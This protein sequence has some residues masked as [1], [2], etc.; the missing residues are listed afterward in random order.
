M[1]WKLWGRFRMYWKNKRDRMPILKRFFGSFFFPLVSWR[2]Y[3]DWDTTDP[4][5]GGTEFLF[6]TISAFVVG[7]LIFAFA[8]LIAEMEIRSKIGFSFVC[9]WVACLGIGVSQS[10]HDIDSW[11]WS[12]TFFTVCSPVIYMM[13]KQWKYPEYGRGRRKLV[14]TDQ[15]GETRSVTF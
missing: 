2:M 10:V 3:W 1:Y 4:N 5:Y 6:V 11:G 12:L 14:Y 7:C 13:C 15:E 9:V 8:G